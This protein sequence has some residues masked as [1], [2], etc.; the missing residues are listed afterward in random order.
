MRMTLGA[1]SALISIPAL[2]APVLHLVRP[3]SSFTQ[4]TTLDACTTLRGRPDSAD[5]NPALFRSHM[6][7]GVK[8]ALGG[9]TDGDSVDTSKKLLF[10]KV[11]EP[12]LR[13]LFDERAF[14]TWGANSAIDFRTPYF[15]LSYDPATVTADVFV[16]NPAFP[17]ISMA[18][19]KSKR[20]G[21]TSGFDIWESEGRT[22]SVGATIFHY[23]RRQYLGTFALVDLTTSEVNELIVFENESGVAGDLGL[24]YRHPSAWVP[25]VSLL[26][27]NFNGGFDPDEAEVRSERHL[28]PLLVYETHSRVSLGKD[29]DTDYGNWGTEVSAPFDGVYKAYY[30]DY[31]TLA[32]TYRLGGMEAQL[33]LARYQQ[34]AGFRFGSRSTAVGVFY[35]RTQPLGEY[36]DQVDSAAGVHLG[37]SL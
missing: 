11:K 31:V 6:S 16:F 7:S 30:S 28:R 18:L 29:W 1:L 34:V 4:I 17:E 22:L 24:A 12:F 9:I 8:F 33:G 19:V 5:C 15:Q 37:V 23:Q 3:D 27:K 36:R 32:G 10:E 35:A 26:V 25:N 13:E 2:A 21:V 20:L 14:T